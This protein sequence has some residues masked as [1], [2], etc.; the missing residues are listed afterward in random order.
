MAQ[1]IVRPTPVGYEEFY[2]LLERGLFNPAPVE[3][4]HTC[5]AA[6]NL[7]IRR[8][9]RRRHADAIA[10][11]GFGALVRGKAMASA[12]PRNSKAPAAGRRFEHSHTTARFR[13]R[14]SRINDGSHV[15]Y[16]G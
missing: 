9:G 6:V 4:I 11:A 14:G 15:D 12:L 5:Q 10:F 3:H 13:S 8:I 2:L 16:V 7:Q 1:P